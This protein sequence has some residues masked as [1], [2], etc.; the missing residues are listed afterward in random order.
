MGLI[1]IKYKQLLSW[2]QNKAIMDISGLSLNLGSSP[3]KAD[4]RTK[5]KSL[6]NVPRVGC[7]GSDDSH[8]LLCGKQDEEIPENADVKQRQACEAYG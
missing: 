2:E 8:E 6:Q 7:D 3:S 4:N 5:I 1:F